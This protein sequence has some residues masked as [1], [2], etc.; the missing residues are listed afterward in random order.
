VKKVL[1]KV[2][3]PSDTIDVSNI[4]EDKNLFLVAHKNNAGPPG[5]RIGNISICTLGKEGK[6]YKWIQ[7]KSYCLSVVNHQYITIKEAVTVANR[8]GYEVYQ[9][10]SLEDIFAFVSVRLY[11]GTCKMKPSLYNVSRSGFRR[12]SAV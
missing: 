6:Y 11:T 12:R 2:P 4:T 8:Q 7:L 10:D 5:Y 9:F 3:P 1:V